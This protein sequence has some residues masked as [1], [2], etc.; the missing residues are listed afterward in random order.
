MDIYRLETTTNT[1]TF[2]FIFFAQVRLA[3]YASGNEVFYM[4]FNAAGSD[5]MT[6]MDQDRIIDSSAPNRPQ[7][8]N[9]SILG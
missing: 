1:F 2:T 8:E 3:V 5:K 4:V 6:W 9:F 7:L